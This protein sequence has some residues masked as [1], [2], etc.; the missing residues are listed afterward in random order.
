MDKLK[1]SLD[2]YR[3]PGIRLFTGYNRG[4][5]VAQAI[6]EEYGTDIE[7]EIPEDVLVI[8][9]SFRTGFNSV[10]PEV[11]LWDIEFIDNKRILK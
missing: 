9:N 2:R 11:K 7:I 10:L 8:S 6:L 3:S 5:L 1:V 4:V